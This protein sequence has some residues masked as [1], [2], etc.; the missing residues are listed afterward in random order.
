MKRKLYFAAV[1]AVAL[2]ACDDP[3]VNVPEI[4]SGLVK[5]NLSVPLAET[6][7]EGTEN[8]KK[9]N[10]LQIYVFDAEDILESYSKVNA[11]ATSVECT[12]GTK[13]IVALV[14]SPE[15]KNN[16]LLM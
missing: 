5:L 12:P 14:N 3:M 15:I 1:A 2:S 9:V 16:I 7:S 6:R 13:K 10:N 8:E 4:D 11:A